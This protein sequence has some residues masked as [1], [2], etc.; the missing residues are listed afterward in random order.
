M[1][2]SSKFITTIT[3]HHIKANKLG[4]WPN[5][6]R[7]GEKDARETYQLNLYPITN[8]GSCRS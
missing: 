4:S 7:Y 8:H 6:K 5:N 1:F 3:S 2:G